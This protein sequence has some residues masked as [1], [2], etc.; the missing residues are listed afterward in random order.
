MTHRLGPVAD[1]FAAQ[2]LAPRSVSALAAGRA[3]VR[4]RSAGCAPDDEDCALRTPFQRDR[5]RI[6]HCKAFR[7]LKH[8]TQVFVAPGGRPLPHPADAHARGR[9]HRPH[10]R[11]RAAPERGPHRGDRR[12]ATTSGT[13]PSATPARRPSTAVLRALRPP[14]PAQRAL[15]AGRRRAGAR[16]PRPEPDRRR[17]ATASSTTPAPACRARS[18]ARIVRLVDRIAYINHD[19]DDAMRAGVLDRGSCRPSRSRCWATPRSQRIDALVHDLVEAS[20]RPARCQSRRWPRRCWRCARS[21]SRTSTGPVAGARRRGGR[22]G[23][24]LFVHSSQPPTTCP[25]TATMSAR[26]RLGGRHDR[27][28]RDPRLR[29]AAVPR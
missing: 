11:P 8:K 2:R 24:A 17:C 23:E 21:C 26:H 4:R 5:D 9:R 29:R 13:R 18:R 15:A 7:R 19:I 25:A 10:R 20:E 14:L 6:V 1:R 16:R 12:S 28:L 3:L 27:P 22:H